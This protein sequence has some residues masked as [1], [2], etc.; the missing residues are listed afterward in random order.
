MTYLIIETFVLLLLA[1]ALGW[2]VGWLMRGRAVEQVRGMALEAEIARNEAQARCRDCERRRDELEE[3]LTAATTANPRAVRAPAPADSITDA[4]VVADPD[5]P[6]P[7]VRVGP[8]AA[9]AATGAA[10]TAGAGRADP[11]GA[12]AADPT[13]ADPD[14]AGLPG[15]PPARL[16]SMPDE[17]DDLKLISGVGPKIE[18]LLNELGICRFDQIAAFTPG[19]IAWVN[20]YLKFKGRI[21]RE[22]WVSQASILAAG[23]DTRVSVRRRRPGE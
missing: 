23:G 12:A 19:N 16:D 13:A 20:G 2:T 9:L 8:G 5:T 17:P 21:E 18:K 3:A 15:E 4:A 22:S 14:P 11:A 6:A 10:D 1:V 7:A